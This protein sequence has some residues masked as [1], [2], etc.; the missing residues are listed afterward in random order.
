MCVHVNIHPPMGHVKDQNPWRSGYVLVFFSSKLDNFAYI[1]GSKI[2]KHVGVS[3]RGG[4][5]PNGGG[6]DPNR[7]VTP[8]NGLYT[9]PSYLPLCVSYISTK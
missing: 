7:V 4:V 8:A 1:T 2:K 9:P 3:T 6:Y 5:R